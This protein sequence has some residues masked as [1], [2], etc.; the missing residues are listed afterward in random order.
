MTAKEIKNKIEEIAYSPNRYLRNGA[1]NIC[2]EIIAS[3]ILNE[4][5]INVVN[6]IKLRIKKSNNTWSID[7]KPNFVSIDVIIDSLNEL[8]K[9]L[10]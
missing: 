2:D 5:E 9:M 3:S 1:L 8:Y 6:E 4:C 10:E 7:D